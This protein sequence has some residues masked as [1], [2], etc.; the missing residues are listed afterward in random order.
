MGLQVQSATKNGEGQPLSILQRQFISFS[1]GG[2]NIEDFDLLAVFPNDRLEKL[3]Y[4]EFEDT[5]SKPTELDGQMFW[6]SVFNSGEI[7]FSL[8]TDGI[9]A[10][11]LEAFKEWFCPGIERELILSEY[12]NRAILARIASAP[13]FSLLPFKS[14]E[15][16]QIGAQKYE[17]I[18]TLYKGD[19]TITF[20]M[21]DPY[22]YSKKDI[23]TSTQQ[24]DLKIVLE[25]G[26]PHISMFGTNQCLIAGNKYY[27]GTAVVA[28]P[29][30]LFPSLDEQ[31]DLKLYY[32]GTAKAFPTLRFTINGVAD[33]SGK[34]TFGNINQTYYF[35]K[36]GNAIMNFSLPDILVAY[37]QVMDIVNDFDGASALDLR[38][39]LRDNVFNYTVRAWAIAA[40]DAIRQVDG[41]L[42]NGY[43]A[44]MRTEMRELFPQ[45]TPAFS[46]EINCKK[47]TV[48]VKSRVME[49]Y[50]GTTE[51]DLTENSGNM[52]KSNYLTISDRVLPHNGTIGTNS[53]SYLNI[54]S[55]ATLNK[56]EIDYKYYY[57]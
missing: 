2:K 30:N 18:T 7:T 15:E 41:S 51:K 8:A 16:V 31:T 53:S 39:Q 37:N 57:L 38:A 32:C 46:F 26:V 27:D 56:F 35:V 29:L 17:A 33:S 45:S 1:Y 52:I 4:A 47:G 36:V 34:I 24:E 12:H 50:G 49:T 11:K 10:S 13:Q 5:T 20:T 19:I 55:N 21:D 3:A 14:S 28:N 9:S 43:K 40:L 25:D 22:W 42:P 6:R 23:I 54:S 44:T 48:S